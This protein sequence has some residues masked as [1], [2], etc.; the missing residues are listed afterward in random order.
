MNPWK[1]QVSN[2]L[3]KKTRNSEDVAIKY[4]KKYVCEVCPVCEDLARTQ[5]SGEHSQCLSKTETSGVIYED[6]DQNSVFYTS[7]MTF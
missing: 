7:K 3:K 5:T 2:F 6:L 1:I 4:R